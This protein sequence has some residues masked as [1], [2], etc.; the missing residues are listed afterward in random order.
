MLNEKARIIVALTAGLCIGGGVGY[1]IAERKIRRTSEEELQGVRDMF[2]RLRDEDQAQARADWNPIPEED[3]ETE[4]FDGSTP[5][6]LAQTA[7]DLGYINEEDVQL[8]RD[9]N[10]IS[11]E[12][13]SAGDEPFPTPNMVE[14]DLREDVEYVHNIRFINPGNDDEND[15]TKWD[16]SPDIPYIIT[17]EEFRIDR[18]EFE[19]LSITYYKGDDTWADEKSQYIPYPEGTVGEVNL[20]HFGLASGDERTLHI[21]NERVMADFEVTLDDGSYTR[22]ILGF[23]IDED[24]V[25]ESKRTIKKM[26]NRE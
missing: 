8:K 2:R 19:K 13:T 4:D 21:R 17:E 18:P 20:E 26:R 22:E 14:E 1:L 23:G 10:Y 15:V 16:R 12:Y 25:K 9:P 11:P 7:V 3:S 5:E 6:S 24:M